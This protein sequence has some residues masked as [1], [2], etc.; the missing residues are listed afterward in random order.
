M[1]KWMSAALTVGILML[2][3]MS[4]GWLSFW[5]FACHCVGIVDHGSLQLAYVPLSTWEAL[6]V[7]P[8]YYERR[9]QGQFGFELPHCE[10]M[11]LVDEP[12]VTIPFWLPFVGSLTAMIVLWRRGRRPVLPGQCRRCGYDLTGNVSG[13]CPECGS[14]VAGMVRHQSM[15]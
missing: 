12:A 4:L 2:W 13:C 6:E 3:V 10:R 11:D 14:V 5:F 1:L 8:V 15:P 9:W 7:T